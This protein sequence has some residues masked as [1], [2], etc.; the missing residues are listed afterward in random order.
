[1]LEPL[2]LVLLEGLCW[3]AVLQGVG[4]VLALVQGLPRRSE[5]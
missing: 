2:P 1:M 4:I 5:S 3:L